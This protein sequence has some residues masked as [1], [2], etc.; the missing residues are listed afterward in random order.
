MFKTILT[1][2]P[3]PIYHR[4]QALF[5]KEFQEGVEE[6][7][8]E[9]QRAA[10]VPPNPGLTELWYSVTLAPQATAALTPRA[11]SETPLLSLNL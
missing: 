10:V 3:P 11:Y 7:H 5:Y 9:W 1:L 6:K 2:E 8:S 4:K